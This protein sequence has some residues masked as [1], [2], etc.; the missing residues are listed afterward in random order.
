M[1]N[2]HLRECAEKHERHTDAITH[3]SEQFDRYHKENTTKFDALA[4]AC[5]AMAKSGERL[6][7]VNDDQ[8]KVLK[9]LGTSRR[10]VIWGL[11]IVPTLITLMQL[12]QMLH[13]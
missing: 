9:V 11:G 6:A 2:V 1:L 12:W 7:G 3:L 4:T 5:A 10:L 13:K 8:L